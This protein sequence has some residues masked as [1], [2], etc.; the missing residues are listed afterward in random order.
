MVA[1]PRLPCRVA[2][3][4][5]TGGLSTSMRCPNRREPGVQG[6]AV[7][8]GRE[9]LLGGPEARPAG[10]QRGGAQALQQP[11]G[12]LHQAGRLGRRHQGGEADDFCVGNSPG[13]GLL[14]KAHWL[15]LRLTVALAPASDMASR[16]PLRLPGSAHRDR[17]VSHVLD[18]HQRPGRK[19]APPAS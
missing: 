17:F 10:R 1:P 18:T 16:L 15:L 12:V 6:G 7:P 14:A 9:A 19:L 4:T 5:V 2:E 13:C 11:G 3:L 8:G